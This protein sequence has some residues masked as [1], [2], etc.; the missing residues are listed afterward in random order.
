[1]D[2]NGYIQEPILDLETQALIEAERLD[3]ALRNTAPKDC[4]I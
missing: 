1:M 4:S 2:D 3:Q